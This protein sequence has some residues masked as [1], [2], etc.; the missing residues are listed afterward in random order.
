MSTRVVSAV[1]GLT[2]EDYTFVPSTD[3]FDELS[4]TVKELS[5]KVTDVSTS[6]KAVDRRMDS[7]D[8]KLASIVEKMT[9]VSNVMKTTKEEI[10][11]E[12]ANG[13][14]KSALKNFVRDATAAF[15]AKLRDAGRFSA[16]KISELVKQ[17]ASARS[18]LD[19]IQELRETV[20]SGIAN[21]G[22]ECEKTLQASVSRIEKIA[23]EREQEWLD[24]TAKLNAGLEESNRLQAQNKQAMARIEEATSAIS[25]AKVDAEAVFDK[26]DQRGNELIEIIKSNSDNHNVMLK[27][28]MWLTVQAVAILLLTAVVVWFA[29][30]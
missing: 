7:Q 16:D 22:K 25:M 6:M 14:W 30:K 15:E 24:C 8:K 11:V 23:E 1:H 19:K 27:F 5:R 20:L 3:E 17:E 4:E 26:V 13:E 18:L 29:V 10:K 21:T 12:L 9:S 28:R 2:S